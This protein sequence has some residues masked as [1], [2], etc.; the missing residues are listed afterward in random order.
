MEKE[1]NGIYEHGYG[2]SWK[3]V[4]VYGKEGYTTSV[5]D[6]HSHGF[7]EVNLILSGNVRILMSDK[8][9]ETNLSHLVLMGPGVPHF[10]VWAKSCAM[11]SNSFCVLPLRKA[12]VACLE[13]SAVMKWHMYSAPITPAR[14]SPPTPMRRFL[15][16]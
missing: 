1:F 13:V 4:L 12:S 15:N 14:K 10:I 16:A 2:E 11:A 3:D 5:A 9:V 6:Y 7:Y 8:S